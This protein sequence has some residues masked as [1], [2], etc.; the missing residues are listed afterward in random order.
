V[1]AA[2]IDRYGGPERFAIREVERPRPGS[3]QLLLRVR[4]AGVNPID[5]KIRRGRMRLLLPARFPLVLGFDAAGEVEEIGPEVHRFAPGDAV[6]AHLASRHG[7]GYA[8]Y[9]LA[10]ES[11][12]AAKPV[13]LSFEE[14]AALPVAGL[15]ALQGLLDRG[16]LEPGDRVLVNGGAGGVGH[17]AVQIAAAHGAEV[18]AVAGPGNQ[19]F[20]RELGARRALDYTREDFTVD[21]ETYR[22]IF[23]AVG[24]RR[25][26]ECE[27]ALAEDGTYVTT[28]VGPA[29]VL[30]GWKAAFAGLLGGARRR[31]RMVRARPS[32]EDLEELARLV[33]QGRLHPVLQRTYELEEIRH[34]HAA[35]E[36]GHVR[37]KIVVRI[38]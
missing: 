17:F 5:W 23:D 26:A 35:S 33:E 21:E 12:A 15:T 9:A 29:I 16:E 11:A 25:F 30:A 28:R 34:A 38:D 31:P 18:S 3:G 32:G 1:R 19:D 24:T 36:S 13:R 27:P 14:A 20:L 37:G 22:L 2:V 8:E 4:A 7:G 10:A 6:F